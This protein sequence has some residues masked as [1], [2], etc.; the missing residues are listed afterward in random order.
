MDQK[1]TYYYVICLAALLILM[2]GV[3]DLSST[4]F[5]LSLAKAPTISADQPI[6]FSADRDNE[7][8]LD[9]YYQKKM[10]YD[11][12]SDSLARIVIAGL[13]FAYSRRVVAKL[14]G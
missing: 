1:K 12:L 3:V 10:L 9:V 4:L 8:F 14:E 2:W 7:Q 11:R 13:V 5:G 6:N